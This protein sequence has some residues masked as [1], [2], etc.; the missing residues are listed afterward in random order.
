MPEI[1]RVGGLQFGWNSTDSR[2]DGQLWQAF[3]SYDWGQKLDR[4]TVYAQTQ[5][6]VPIGPTAGQYGVENFTLKMLWEQWEQLKKYLALEAPGTASGGRGPPS[7]YGQTFFN[8]QLTADEPLSPGAVPIILNAEDCV[9]I[10]EKSSG[11]KGAAALEAEI[12]LWV[13]SLTINGLSAFSP[14]VGGI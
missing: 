14:A 5:D 8:Y 11:A 9:W 1:I 7:T 12:G 13:R 4:E 2:V 10:S 3:T 6:G